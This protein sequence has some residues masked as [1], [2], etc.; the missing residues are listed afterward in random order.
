MQEDTTRR[1]L[2]RGTAGTLA[3]GTGISISSQ[4]A[5]AAITDKEYQINI[6]PFRES[7]SFEFEFGWGANPEV[8]SEPLDGH[9]ES[10]DRTV[11]GSIDRGTATIGVDSYTLESI[12][13]N[14]GSLVFGAEFIEDNFQSTYG[15]P[16]NDNRPTR[17]CQIEISGDGD[18][19]IV[20]PYVTGIH[21]ARSSEH[22]DAWGVGDTTDHEPGNTVGTSGGTRS[23]SIEVA[24]TD[25]ITAAEYAGDDAHLDNQFRRSSRDLSNRN[26]KH[27]GVAIFGEISDVDKYQTA[28]FKK[29][30]ASLTS[31]LDLYDPVAS[32]PSW[33]RLDGDLS[34]DMFVTDVDRGSQWD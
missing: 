21:T 28:G 17:Y 10:G 3:L 5:A 33:M 20:T 6:R 11:T 1:Q 14:D 16:D 2:L 18:Y 23:V 7:T 30:S 19:V 26:Q 12:D 25:Q 8:A 29:E 34:V 22:G 4:S 32:R 9:C 31:T 27:D 13:L 24:P 15:G